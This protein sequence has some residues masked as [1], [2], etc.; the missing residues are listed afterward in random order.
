MA[1]HL[2]GAEPLAEPIL[3]YCWLKSVKFESKYNSDTKCYFQNVVC[4]SFVSAS[5]TFKQIGKIITPG[6]HFANMD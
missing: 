1:C 2:I 3:V 5:M 4:K 6:A